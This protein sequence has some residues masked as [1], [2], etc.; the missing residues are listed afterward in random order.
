LNQE[1]SRLAR[2]SDTGGAHLG[3]NI[4]GVNV[5]AGPT[6]SNSVDD[7]NRLTTTGSVKTTQTSSSKITSKYRSQH[8]T[9]FTVSTENRFESTSKRVIRNPNPFTPIDLLYFNQ[10]GVEKR[11]CPWR[12]PSVNEAR[13]ML[14]SKPSNIPFASLVLPSSMRSPEAAASYCGNS[15]YSSPAAKRAHD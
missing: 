3:I 5:Q 1:L 12:V 4:D 7:G 15:A 9:T 8:K 13:D 6:T 2:D 14:D 11:A 10:S